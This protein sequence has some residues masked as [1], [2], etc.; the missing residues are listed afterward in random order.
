MPRRKG[1]SQDVHELK[2][3]KEIVTPLNAEADGFPVPLAHMQ[4][5][6]WPSNV[7]IPHFFPGVMTLVIISR[8]CLEKSQEDEKKK[9]RNSKTGMREK[10][11]IVTHSLGAAISHF[12]QTC[13]CPP[14]LCSDS[15]ASAAASSACFPPPSR[16]ACRQVTGSSLRSRCRDCRY[17]C[18]RRA[19]RNAVV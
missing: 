18:S 7:N 3:R 12:N 9:K 15:S 2:R 11:K 10:K 4:S 8:R 5:S 13:R 17:P 19:G 1:G 14:A 16:P 6:T